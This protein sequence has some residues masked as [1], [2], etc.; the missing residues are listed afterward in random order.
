M[1]LCVCVL[2]VGTYLNASAQNATPPAAAGSIGGRAT[3]DGRPLAGLVIT[4][5]VSIGSYRAAQTV[6]RATTGPDGRYTLSN[7]PP[8]EY[9]ILPQAA[10]L[11]VI[12]PKIVDNYGR[13]GFK[14]PLTP[15]ARETDVDFELQKGGVITGRVTDAQGNPVPNR[16]VRLMLLAAER[17]LP[18]KPPFERQSPS[19][20]TNDGSTRRFPSRRPD[21]ATAGDPSTAV[22]TNKRSW[23]GWI[24]ATTDDRGVYRAYG[25]AAG[26][27]AVGV[28]R[29]DAMAIIPDNVLT[30]SNVGSSFYRPTAFYPD[31]YYPAS[32]DPENAGLVEVTAGGERNAVDLKLGPVIYPA[33]YAVRGRLAD[34]LALGGTKGAMVY[35][36]RDS[37]PAPKEH[38]GFTNRDARA[39]EDGSFTLAG[40]APGRY[41]VTAR[42]EGPVNTVFLPVEIEIANGDVNDIVLTA[43]SGLTITGRLVADNNSAAARPVPLD[44]V[45]LM[46]TSYPEEFRNATWDQVKPNP[47]GTFKAVGLDPGRVQVQLFDQDTG[48]RASSVVLN[49]VSLPAAISGNSGDPR[50]S[51]F[52]LE[53]N[54][55]IDNLVV[56]AAYPNLTRRV[57]V[58]R[59]GGEWPADTYI[60][61]DYRQVEGGIRGWGQP[62]D[63]LGNFTM[64]ELLP[65]EYR[66]DVRV[67]IRSGPGAG[68]YRTT[69]TTQVTHNTESDYVVYLN[70]GDRP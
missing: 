9:S 51:G 3:L 67:I 44:T 30:Q 11:A 64:K 1:L 17:P 38:A 33:L 19:Q 13:R 39:G 61:L 5:T 50:E 43:Q 60:G 20:P 37:N 47:D 6:A 32:S 58:R 14:V 21:T 65:G 54:R 4:A 7:L 45:T 59:E 63:G 29:D 18:N 24:Y 35:V 53:E 31:T 26:R 10:A 8:G 40:L 23:Q 69:A 57:A 49:G 55:P 48:L 46:V 56:R 62:L 25:L 41:Q 34:P 2:S 68:T 28:N 70:I 36:R 27:Y 15:G 16:R 42:R 12:K 66:L 52:V 22:W